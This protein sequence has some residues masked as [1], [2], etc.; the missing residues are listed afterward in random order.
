MEIIGDLV[1]I[2]GDILV[3]D[4]VYDLVDCGDVGVLCC[5]GCVF[6]I[7]VCDFLELEIGYGGEMSGGE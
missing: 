4:V 1:E 2:V 6:V 3:V 5:V 7:I